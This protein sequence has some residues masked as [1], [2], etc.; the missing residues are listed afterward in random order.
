MGVQVTA[1]FS[2]MHVARIPITIEHK[3]DPENNG[4]NDDSVNQ[5]HDHPASRQCHQ[6]NQAENNQCWQTNHNG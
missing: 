2:I 3:H 6:P 5:V 4:T 1:K